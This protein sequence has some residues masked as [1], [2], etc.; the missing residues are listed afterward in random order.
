MSLL[1][2][3]LRK[4]EAAKNKTEGDGEDESSSLSLEPQETIENK[5]TETTV[6]P[7][8]TPA[9][10]NSENQNLEDIPETSPELEQ[11]DFELE[12]IPDE[13]ALS[14][15][16]SELVA[17][18][19]S[20]AEIADELLDDDISEE[21]FDLTMDGSDELDSSTPEP[22][23]IE[24]LGQ[25]SENTQAETLEALG[26]KSGGVDELHGFEPENSD[27]NELFEQDVEQEEFNAIEAEE[28]LSQFERSV[29]QAEDE[30]NKS[31]Q[32][33]L[34][35]QTASSLFQAKKNTQQNKRNRALL[36]GLLI[37]LFPIGGGLYW[38]YSSSLN[39]SNMFPTNAVIT[40]PP[41]GFLGEV[42]TTDTEIAETELALAEENTEAINIEANEAVVVQ[43]EETTTSAPNT[44]IDSSAGIDETPAVLAQNTQ[45]EDSLNESSNEPAVEI[46]LTRTTFRPEVNPDL[47]AAYDS[48]QQGDLG[49]ARRLY[50]QVLE[51]QPNNRDALLGLAIITRQEGN[52]AQAQA[53]YSR[54]LQLNPRDPL[55]RAGLLE[56]G[57]NINATQQESQ[58]RA[59]QNEYPNVAPLAFALGNL[60]A[61]QSRWNEA[62]NAYFDALLIANE[63]DSDAV[64]PD[65]AFNLAV[66]L[67]RLNQ[68]SLAYSYYQQ[69]LDLSASSPTGFSMDNLNQRMAYLEEVLQ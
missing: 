12:A 52:I 45:S 18:P 26:K 55:A 60:F 41:E 13:A 53:L 32:A 36:L 38:F 33:V 44:T 40:P 42:A 21:S 46:R 34:D 19:Q 17:P 58:L 49:Q 50:A 14:D 37:A 3:A 69:A 10:D 22:E 51:T 67:E 9:T 35:R 29:N 56:S 11:V 23:F 4:A 24:P 16:E 59:L 7:E 39:T 28:E 5:N 8:D 25:V 64:S 47:M 65:Y 62:Q 6:V 66:S 30:H 43:A 31:E 48:Y 15:E 57:Q 61:S 27:S 68:L 54:L 63:V 2:E 1:M 20:A